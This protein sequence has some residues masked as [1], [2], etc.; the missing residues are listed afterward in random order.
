VGGVS[1]TPVRAIGWLVIAVL[2]TVIF[3]GVGIFQAHT[4]FSGETVTAHVDRCETHRVYSRHGS[5]N[6]TDCYGTWK[7][8]DGNEHDGEIPGADSYSDEGKD[9]P[10][11][12]LGDD[13]VEDS[14]LGA[15]W[16]LGV[17]AL[18]VVLSIAAGFAVRKARRRSGG[19]SFVGGLG[20]FRRPPT[21]YGPPP[22]LFGQP[23]APYPP[24]GQPGAPP[25]GP[26]GQPAQPGQPPSPGQPSPPGQ[27]GPP[28]PYSQ[29]AQHGQPGQYGPPG[30]Y[31]A[32][33]YGPPPVPP[34]YG[35][36]SRP[37][38]PGPYGAGGPP[39]DPTAAPPAGGGYPPSPG[40]YPT[41]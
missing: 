2:M 39:A 12:A 38:A 6:E 33:Q 10:L 25:Y 5:H 1:I 15:L 11:R 30:P 8:A 17:A 35:A 37:G 7:T 24:Y 3:T 26:P 20:R 22:P 36:P 9:V 14:T 31:G 32:P 16:P 21:R 19:G 23:S 41:R 29:P 27:Y 13:V 34:Q 4:Y 40:G 18:G 28:A